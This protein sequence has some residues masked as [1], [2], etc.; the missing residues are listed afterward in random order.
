[1]A[2]SPAA[3]SC[4]T[5]SRASG[6]SRSPLAVKRADID[7]YRNWLCELVDAAGEPAAHGQPRFA[8]ATIARRL[9]TV[10]SLLCLA[11]R[12]AHDRRIARRARRRP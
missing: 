5:R 9:T 10:R 12:S 11:R 1:V 6:S 2:A 3:V 7:R 4:H 8:P